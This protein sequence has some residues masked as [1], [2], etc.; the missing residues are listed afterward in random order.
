MDRFEKQRWS[1]VYPADWQNPDPQGRYNLV[2]LGGGTAGLVAAAGA[3]GLGAKVALI[4]RKH[5]G[6]DCLNTGCVPS[7]ALLAAAHR[8]AAVRRALGSDRFEGELPLAFGSVMER[9][10]HLRAEISQHD[11]AKRFQDLGVDVFLGNGQFLSRDQVQVGAQTLRFRK[12]VLATGGTPNPLPLDLPTGLP[13]MT[14]ENFF[15]LESLPRELLVVGGGPIGCELAQAMAQLGA[16]VTLVEKGDRLLKREDRDAAQ[17]LADQLG[18]DGVTVLTHTVV[19]RLES[20][21]DGFA[22]F[23]R[24]DAEL[25]KVPVDA[26]LVALGRSPNLN[27]LGLEAAGIRTENGRLVVDDYYRTTNRNVYAAGDVAGNWQ[28]THAAD[29]MSRAILQN[30]LFFGRKKQ[31]SLVVPRCTYTWPELASV[32]LSAAEAESRNDVVTLRLPL[33]DIDR[34]RLEGETIG[35]AEV[36]LKAG[37]D[38]V[39]GA[40]VVAENA[41][42]LISQFSL[43]ITQRLGLAAFAATQYPYPTR[44]EVV[45]KLGDQYNRTRLT[46]T[47]ARWMRIWLRWQR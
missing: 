8:S 21:T 29:F 42:E 39:L 23:L 44:A 28:F 11:S 22:A 18:R 30:A 7:K 2:V 17:C 34:N 15:D 20:A 12:A 43:A 38:R 41:G 40:T 31:S 3:A 47:I 26:V 37:S 16:R 46:P 1:N 32:G 25:R 36:R 19:E 35:W 10:R 45:R 27:G 6:G 24:K 14:S 9:M 5:L 33:E 13:V 4:E